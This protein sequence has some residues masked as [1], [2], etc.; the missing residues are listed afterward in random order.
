MDSIYN[1]NLSL[2]NAIVGE[3]RQGSERVGFQVVTL[4]GRTA[5]LASS[6]ISRSC[7][8]CSLSKSIIHLFQL[9]LNTS[10]FA[11]YVSPESS[12]WPNVGKYKVD[13]ASFESLA[14]PELQVGYGFNL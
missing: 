6:T 13:V 14:L 12:R 1:V 3:V 5:P 7:H 9:K 10:S 8:N 4:D 11:I 2:S